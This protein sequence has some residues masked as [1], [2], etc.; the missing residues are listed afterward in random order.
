[1]PSREQNA[2]KLTVVQAS[3]TGRVPRSP[4]CPRLG[5]QS[6]CLLKCGHGQLWQKVSFLLL[7]DNLAAEGL[8][9]LADFSNRTAMGE[10]EPINA[11]AGLEFGLGRFIPGGAVHENIRRLYNKVCGATEGVAVGWKCRDRRAAVY[12]QQ[13]SRWSGGCWLTKGRLR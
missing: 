7:D 10:K 9:D 1:M 3:S 11:T 8:L 6:E 12:L 13:Q 5:G 2:T 4:D